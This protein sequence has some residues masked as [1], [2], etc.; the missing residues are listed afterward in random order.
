ML[1]EIYARE[2]VCGVEVCEGYCV[3]DIVRDL[4]AGESLQSWAVWG[5]LCKRCCERVCGVEVCEGYFVKD[6]VIEFIYTQE[7]Y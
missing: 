6:V 1:W 3:R 7:R 2:R 5:I 4:R